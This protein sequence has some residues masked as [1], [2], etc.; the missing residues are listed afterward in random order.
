M[1]NHLYNPSFVLKAVLSIVLGMNPD[2][3]ITTLAINI[4]KDTGFRRYVKHVIQCRDGELV[5]IVIFFDCMAIHVHPPH[6]IL[7]GY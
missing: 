3:V 1:T 4:L 6:I 7:L 2:L 5:F